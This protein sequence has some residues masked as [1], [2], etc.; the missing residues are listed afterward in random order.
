MDLGNV[1]YLVLP[2]RIVVSPA[3]NTVFRINWRINDR[4]QSLYFGNKSIHPHHFTINVEDRHGFEE[5]RR[6]NK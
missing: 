4:T 2:F 1:V 6:V 3:R 5:D